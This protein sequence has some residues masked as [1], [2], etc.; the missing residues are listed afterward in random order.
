MAKAKKSFDEIKM[1][2]ATISITMTIIF[3]NLFASDVN[4]KESSP[5]VTNTPQITATPEP[6]IETVKPVPAFTGKIY[7]GGQA[8]QPRVIIK[9]VPRTGGGGNGG[10]N[11]SGNVVTQTSSS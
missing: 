7:L 5:E 8:P 11:N 1:M 4:Q 10:G 6:V 2:I 9:T 3:W